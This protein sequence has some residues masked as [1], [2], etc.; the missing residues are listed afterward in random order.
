MFRTV[1]FE[2]FRN[3][4]NFRNVFFE[5]FRIFECSEMRI[6]EVF[7]F[8]RIKTIDFDLVLKDTPIA[9]VQKNYLGSNV[10]REWD[11]NIDFYVISYNILKLMGG[12]GGLVF[13]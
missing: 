2:G 10:T 8:S 12:L 7:N 4:R 11:Y 1:N 9:S 13:A 3:F 6:S 5:C